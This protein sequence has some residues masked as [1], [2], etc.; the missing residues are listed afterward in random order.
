LTCINS[1]RIVLLS[2]EKWPTS[3]MI[4]EVERHLFAA[5]NGD[6]QKQLRV[7]RTDLGSDA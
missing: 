7:E 2:L 5:G 4:G 1:P 6:G 3:S